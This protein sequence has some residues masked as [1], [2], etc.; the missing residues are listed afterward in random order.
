ML[1]T[2]VANLRSL[3]IQSHAV[4]KPPGTLRTDPERFPTDPVPAGMTLKSREEPAPAYIS[5]A[6]T[7][8]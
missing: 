2:K 3:G 1:C 5:G 8:R 4:P 6:R 7:R